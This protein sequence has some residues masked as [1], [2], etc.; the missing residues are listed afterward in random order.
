MTTFTLRRFLT[1]VFFISIRLVLSS[2]SPPY[3]EKRLFQ[4]SPE[5]PRP[6]RRFIASSSVSGRSPTVA[7]DAIAK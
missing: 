5:I 3:L 6:H 4:Y 7:D 1:Q 2:H